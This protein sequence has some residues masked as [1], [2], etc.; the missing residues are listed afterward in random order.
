MIWW[1]AV[2]ISILFALI[3]LPFLAFGFHLLTCIL[4]YIF[5]TSYIRTG[6]GHSCHVLNALRFVSDSSL[7]TRI[8]FLQ[9]IDGICDLFHL[10]SFTS[11]LFFSLI[12][13]KL[14]LYV[15]TNTIAK[16]ASN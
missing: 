12:I 11:F 13:M 3:G 15:V 6:G 2:P 7:D 14:A 9:P 16:R 10:H 5:D 8:D 4:L 1:L